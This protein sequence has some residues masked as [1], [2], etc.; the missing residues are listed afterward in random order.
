MGKECK[1]TPEQSVKYQKIVDDVNA[2]NAAAAELTREVEESGKIKDL[3]RL[4]ELDSILAPLQRLKEIPVECRKVYG[5]STDGNNYACGN[6][7]CS[8]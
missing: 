1:A 6:S 2:A 4:S 7:G 3:E 5:V 8:Y